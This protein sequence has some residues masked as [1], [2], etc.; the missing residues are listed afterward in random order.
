[1]IRQPI[2]TFF[3]QNSFFVNTPIFYHSN[4]FFHAL[5]TVCCL[6]KPITC[7]AAHKY[8]SS[9]SMCNYRS[10]IFELG[11]FFSQIRPYCFEKRSQDFQH[12]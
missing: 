9:L 3:S 1:M 8:W 6:R 12:A 11:V 10:L 2:L 5:G 4:I 7:A